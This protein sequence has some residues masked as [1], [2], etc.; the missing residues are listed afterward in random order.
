MTYCEVMFSEKLESG[1]ELVAHSIRTGRL[2]LLVGG[3]IVPSS[4]L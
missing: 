3:A 2:D 4:I 1:N